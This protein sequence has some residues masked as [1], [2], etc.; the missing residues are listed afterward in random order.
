MRDGAEEIGRE[1]APPD[2]YLQPKKFRLRLRCLRCGHEYRSKPLVAVPRVDPS[3]PREECRIEREVE[4]R[5]AERERIERMLEER[6]PPAQGGRNPVVGVV[7]R[8]AEQVMKDYKLT[9]LNDN[10]RTGDIAAPKL[11]PAQQ[12]AADSFFTG[13][14]V[15]RKLG[16]RRLAARVATLGAQVLNARGP[17]PS[18]N[19]ARIQAASGRAGESA[20]V[21]RPTGEPHMFNFR[22]RS[23]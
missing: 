23:G 9:D 4:R 2:G 19:I 16:G 22:P 7:D 14:E 12:R 5:L 13:Q 3:C 11:P 8:V 1:H 15:A 21:A 17:L 20:L 10:M 6:R 18:A